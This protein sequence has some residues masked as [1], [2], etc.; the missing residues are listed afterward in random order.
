MPEESTHEE[1]AKIFEGETSSGGV[2][3][4]RESS[5]SERPNVF[6]ENT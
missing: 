1:A 4:P 6:N 5:P 2:S 3:T